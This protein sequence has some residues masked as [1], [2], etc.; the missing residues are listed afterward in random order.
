MLHNK[1]LSLRAKEK[2]KRMRWT[3]TKRS[4]YKHNCN[5]SS[6]R[7]LNSQSG[8][9]SPR[10]KRPQSRNSQRSIRSNR[11]K[12]PVFSNTSLRITRSN[13]LQSRIR[14]TP[15][16][17]MIRNTAHFIERCTILPRYAMLLR[18]R[19]RLSS[20]SGSSQ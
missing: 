13:C 8:N 17:S 6:R 2:H 11:M 16:E 1:T 18:T 7:R 4:K 20:M 5:S 12:F 19:S 14:K 10:S 9:N 15:R 3:R